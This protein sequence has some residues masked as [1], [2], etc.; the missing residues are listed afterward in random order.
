MAQTLSIL[1]NLRIAG[2]MV[3]DD[4]TGAFPT[5]PVAGMMV[6]KSQVLYAYM[7]VEGT[8]QWYPLVR[9][10]STYT[11]L[12]QSAALEW[13]VVHD[14]NTAD[15]MYQVQDD[16]GNPV[17]PAGFVY[18]DN[19]SFKLEFS[20]AI[21]GKVVVLGSGGDFENALDSR[22]NNAVQKTDIGAPG[23]VAGLDSNAL[24]LKSN[25]PALTGADVGLDKVNN[26]SDLAKP[27]ST[28]TQTALNTKVDNSDVGA[29]NGV[30]PL[31]AGGKIDPSF[32]LP[33]YHDNGTKSSGTATLNYALGQEQRVQVGG[34]ISIALSNL[35]AAGQLAEIMLELVN[36]GAH[37]ITWPTI[38]W[39]NSDGT[40]T[41]SF[42]SNG[43]TLQS[44]GTDWIM[45][46]TRDGGTTVYGK[47]MR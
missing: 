36:G 35:P 14:L 33:V 5:S 9:K 10:V 20:E 37:T 27:I 28:A 47:V 19:N 34:N 29:A 25:L 12:Q 42:A 18:V 17:Q 24:L 31:N 38:N 13:V 41:T 40:T 8:L 32:T 44:A 7:L 16:A 3:L 23:G 39:I 15:V 46:W 1:S 6:I 2:A 26:T 45:L 30:A 43:I 21:T 4:D 11:H 22:I